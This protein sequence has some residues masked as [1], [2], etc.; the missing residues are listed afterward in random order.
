MNSRERPSQTDE[1]PLAGIRILEFGHTVMGPS[2]SMVL[3]DLGADV[4]KVEPP[5]GDRT[6]ANVGFGSALFPVFNRN[7]RSI[8]IDIKNEAG[9]AVIH[10]VIAGADALIENFAHGT[11]ERLGLGYEALS[12]AYPRLVYCSLKGFLSGPYE[13][14][15]ALDEIVQFMGGLAY[16]TGPRGMP[17]R[18]G[19]SVVDIMGGMFGALGIMAALRERERT[20]RGQLVQSALFESTAF[21]VAQHMG[22]Q[23][24]TGVAPPP[25]PEK[26]S[27]WAI[28][29]PFQTADGKTVFVGITSDNHWRSFCTGFGVEE[30]LSDPALKTNPQRARARD[31][32]M[33]VV[34]EKFAPETFDSLVA[35]LERLNI[36]F[37]PL[38]Q[39]GDLFDDRHLNHGGRMLNLRLPTGKNAKIP[40]LPLDM[41]GRRTRIRQQPPEMGNCTR[42]VLAEAGY[43]AAQIDELVAQRVVIAADAVV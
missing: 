15:A 14:R 5:E 7:K 19:A 25:M 23:A 2:C 43:T 9:K 28:Y 27:S 6:R 26:A 37:G 12:A 18:A 42:S 35:K 11:M 21:L 34:T 30:L 8:A 22:Q 24:L 40:G 16:M 13:K 38:A 17:L 36:P 1:L 39:P 20:G 10:R 33:P 4:I 31:K 3:A 32:I 41:G 29:D